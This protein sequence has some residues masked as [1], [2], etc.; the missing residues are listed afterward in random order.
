[1]IARGPSNL[2]RVPPTEG[3]FQRLE[4]VADA[5]FTLLCTPIPAAQ[6]LAM[7]ENQLQARERL[8]KALVALRGGQ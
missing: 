3:R 5:A 1:M 6:L 4:A 2:Q 7:D 8:S